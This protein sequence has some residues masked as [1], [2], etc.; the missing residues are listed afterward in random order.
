MMVDMFIIVP[1]VAFCVISFPM[2]RRKTHPF[3]RKHAAY[4]C[5]TVRNELGT[6]LLVFEIAPV[7]RLFNNHNIINR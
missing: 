1:C 5:F 3:T 4:T 7:S 2:N 6:F